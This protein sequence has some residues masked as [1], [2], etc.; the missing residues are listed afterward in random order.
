MEI[1]VSADASNYGI[2]ARIAHKLPDG[3]V[4]PTSYASRSLTQ[5]EFNYSQIEIEGLALIFAVTRFHRISVY[6]ANRLQRWALTL[7]LYDF[8][9]KYVST[10]SFGYADVL[11]RL[12][13]TNVLSNEDYVIASIELE[14]TME[15]IVKQSVE[16]LPVTFKMIQSGTKSDAVLKQVKQFVQTAWPSSQSK[17]GNSQLQQFYQRRE[18]LS[19]VADCLIYGNRLVIPAKFRDRALR[20]LHKGHPG[21]ERMRSVAR[22]YVY[23]PGIEEQI[24]QCVR[25]CVEC[26]RVAKTNSKTNLESWPSPKKPWQRIHA[27]YAEPFNGNY[28]LIVVDA[29]SKWP[30]VVSTKR[31]TTS[32]TV[33]MFREIFARNGLPETLVTANGT[34]PSAATL[35]S[36]I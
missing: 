18:S 16:A 7:L 26:S 32:A 20:L 27:D 14:D 9:I 29:F 30:E 6:T 35:A 25:S 10:D 24:S 21:V 5:T 15:Y 8:N 36:C 2:G 3:S 17:I 11:S 28:Y 12:I 13:N 22:S 31:I 1:I 33:A 19:I 4:K 23:W 34:Q